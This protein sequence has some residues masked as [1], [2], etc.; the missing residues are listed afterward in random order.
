MRGMALAAAGGVA[1]AASLSGFPA[2]GGVA[3]VLS[4]P[5]GGGEPPVT[6]TVTVNGATP[7]YC[8]YFPRLP[9]C[10]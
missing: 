10:R 3:P 4:A 8:A 2:S 6:A 7:W 9:A 5:S 1:L